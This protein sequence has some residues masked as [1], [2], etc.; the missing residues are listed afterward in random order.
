MKNDM[1]KEEERVVVELLQ[2]INTLIEYLK[3][4][5][6]CKEGNY[7]YLSKVKNIL[8]NKSLN[9]FKNI[10]NHLF[11]DFRMLYDSYRGDAYM[12]DLMDKAD[13]IVE[14]NDL[15]KR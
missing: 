5:G 4:S 14:N 12:E 11:M 2:I 6:R 13:S 9:G 15:F 8:E 3:K 7:S 10:E 1:T